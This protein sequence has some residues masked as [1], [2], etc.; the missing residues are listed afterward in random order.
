MPFEVGVEVRLL[1]TM[2]AFDSV[3]DIPQP[4]P[5]F[6]H[7]RTCERYAEGAGFPK[8]LLKFGSVLDAYDDLQIVRRRERVSDCSQERMLEEMMGDPLIRYVMVRDAKAGC[9][10]FR[11]ERQEG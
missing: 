10:D 4:G 9:Y 5:V 11:V 3:A 6:I 2:N 8:D 1:M 7:E